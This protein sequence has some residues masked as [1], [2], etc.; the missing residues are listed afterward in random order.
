MK[1][2]G[3]QPR[4]EGEARRFGGDARLSRASPVNKGKIYKGRVNEA[5]LSFWSGLRPARGSLAAP[6]MRASRTAG[7][8]SPTPHG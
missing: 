3:A 6:T 1:V 8:R 4:D 2:A 7:P 5:G